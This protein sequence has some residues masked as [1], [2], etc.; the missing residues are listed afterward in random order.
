[1][2]D[3]DKK[4]DPYDVAALEKSL[5]DSASRVST[6]WVSFLIFSLYL[7]TAAGTVTHKQLFLDE[8]TKLP[9]VNIELPLW[10]FFF[11]APILF[12]IYHAYVLMQVI[13]LARTAA[14]YNEAV[15]NISERD[16]LSL[17]EN[18]SLRQRLANTLFAQILAG[19]PR[20]REGVFGWLLRAMAWITLAI[21]PLLILLAF[22]FVFLP[23]HSPLATWMHR[24]LIALE[25][26]MIFFL[27]PMVFDPRWE[28]RWP[29]WRNEI[30]RED[31]PRQRGVA[32]ILRRALMPIAVCALFATLS[33]ALATFPGEPHV[34]L[35]SGHPVW[36]VRCERWL[37]DRFDRLQLAQL[38]AVDDEKLAKIESFAA[39]RHKFAF[40]SRRTRTLQDRDFACGNFQFG[41][42]RRMSLNRSSFVGANLSFASMRG[43]SLAG[44]ELQ[45]AELSLADL[46]SAELEGANLQGANLFQTQLHGAFL[47]NAELQGAQLISTYMKGATLAGANLQGARIDYAQL[48]GSSLDKALLQGAIVTN[49]K[50]H[51]V[52]LRDTSLQGVNFENSNLG[53]AI[54][55]GAKVWRTRNVDCEQ[56]EVKGVDFGGPQFPAGRTMAH[57]IAAS[58]VGI[59]RADTTRPS[60]EYAPVGDR[61]AAAVRRMQIGLEG[62]NDDAAE[63]AAKTWRDCE[64]QA[65]NSG[66]EPFEKKRVAFLRALVCTSPD[67]PDI[68]TGVVMNWLNLQAI[69][70]RSG[71]AEPLA[72]GLLG[73]DG[74]ECAVTK[75]LSAPIIDL[76]R[77]FA[78]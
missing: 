54:I 47:A 31:K 65:L 4:I 6:I 46:R 57:Y 73:E 76:L 72:K 10:W 29:A 18:A 2:A 77:R 53:G 62:P 8:P 48:A 45:G 42:F 40:E 50:L 60:E 55:V 9:I 75:S 38:D 61:R 1:M 66:S 12:V 49:S 20:E 70:D 64:Q 63:T 37:G 23:Y 17:E 11:L 14:T 21:S 58:T 7:V 52:S 15:S 3:N 19:S 5:N 44:A 69:I 26:A 71:V 36:E 27:W 78:S 13:L 34:N 22:Q 16:G 56:A 43:V 35:L 33:L 59:P 24:A 28:L 68:I 67:G 41:D 25:L 39:Q 51:L 32:R 30:A 74:S